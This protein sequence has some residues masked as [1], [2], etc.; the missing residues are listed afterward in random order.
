M[1][2]IEWL[3]QVFYK[4]LLVFEV[5]RRI[6]FNLEGELEKKSSKEKDP[7]DFCNLKHLITRMRI[8]GRT[9]SSLLI[10]AC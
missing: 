9:L 10:D 3:Y 8:K 5:S 7:I 4:Y 2:K 1:E 6:V